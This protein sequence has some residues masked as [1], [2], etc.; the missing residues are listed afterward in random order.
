ME[1]LEKLKLPDKIFMLLFSINKNPGS[2]ALNLKL[3]P[4]KID[5]KVL[6]YLEKFPLFPLEIATK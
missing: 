1:R 5:G 4:R 6:K 2:C 3:K